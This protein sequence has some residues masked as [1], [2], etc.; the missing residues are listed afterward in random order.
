[1]NQYTQSRQFRRDDRARVPFA[2]IAILLLIT[3]I[4]IV[5]YLEVRGT[6]ELETD[7]A[8]AMD[9]AD[10]AVQTELREASM[11][12]TERAATAPLT[13]PANTTYGT[14]LDEERPFESYIEWL[15][16][17]EASSRFDATTQ[18]VGDVEATISVPEVTD[19]STFR[20]ALDRVQLSPERE[21]GEATGMVTVTLDDIEISAIRDGEELATRTETVEVS[22]PTPVIQQHERTQE[23]Q[24]RLNAGITSSGFSQRFNARI[25]A[26]GWARGYA[27]YSGMPVTEVIANRHIEPSVNS[28][29]F[30]TQQD[31]FGATDPRLEDS[32]RRGW[33]C[34]A[35]QD[36]EELYDGY[37]PGTVDVSDDICEASEWLFGEQHTGELPEAPEALDLLGNTPGMDE[38]ETISVNETAYL[39]LRTL[40]SGT[41]E[42]SIA[43]AIER[44]FTIDTAIDTDIETTSPTFG[45]E[46]PAPSAVAVESEKTYDG[47]DISDSGTIEIPDEGEEYYRFENVGVDIE[48]TET[49][50]WVWSDNEG[51]QRATTTAEDT[52]AVTL[53]LALAENETAPALNIH[54]FNENNVSYKYN[55][56]PMTADD[57]TVPAPPDGFENYADREKDIATE[58][59]DATAGDELEDWLVSHWSGV[60]NESELSLPEK[61]RITLDVNDEDA[62]ITTII[63]DIAALQSAVETLSHTFERA[64]LIHTGDGGPVGELIEKLNGKRVSYLER[65]DE[66][67]NVGQQ[68]VYEARYA[69]FELLFDDLGMV[70]EAHNEVMG[71]LGDELSGVDSSLDDAVS[72][73]QQGISAEPDSNPALDSP[74]ITPE[75]T[76]EISGSPTYLAGETITTDEVPAVAQDAN[77]SS[78]AMKNTNHL[79]LPYDSIVSGII[80]RV[81]SVIGLGS[82]DA[83]ITLKT[84]GEALRAG[85]LAESA[86]EAEDDYAERTQLQALND[87]VRMAVAEALDSFPRH[88]SQAM[89]SELYDTVIERTFDTAYPAAVQSADVAE[90]HIDEFSHASLAAI[91]LGNGSA[92]DPLIDGVTDA[93]DDDTIDR[94]TYAENL[95]SDDWQEVIAS[96]VHPAV[97]N[98]TGMATVTLSDTDTI[99]ALDTQVRQALQNVSTDIIEDRL[100]E[101]LGDGVFDL[102]EYDDWVDGI[103]KPMRVP[104]GLPLLPVP[105]MWKATVNVW[106]VEADGK[107]A[108][109]ELKANMSAPGRTSTTTYVRENST[110]EHKIGGEKQTLGGVDPIEFDGRSMLVVVVPPGGLG[111]GDRDDVDPECS[112][113]YPFTG[114]FNTEYTF[115]GSIPQQLPP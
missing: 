72:H 60:T 34:M 32:V 56:G 89:V 97:V 14:E 109:F 26:L 99:E 39:P 29:V 110:V 33:F 51:T 91:A 43:G 63:E 94:P 16:H 65:D 83:E 92:T 8:V 79:K 108:R 115:C 47:L 68:A 42:H 10:A 55:R 64:D 74:D 11:A 17:D 41:D 40:V 30:R 53:T 102:S 71:G 111:V 85:E 105:G 22:V 38:E 48:I 88:F 59:V 3:T 23:F 81:A 21:G 84:A 57:R 46:Q 18:Q 20:E 37:N 66:Y 24:E 13:E 4:G 93:L 103:D 31:V 100:D 27:Q 25:Y 76:Y 2:V 107:Y 62:V 96:A 12:A 49:K 78:L 82:S 36:G 5:G 52:L 77:F 86:T 101:Y 7:T 28:A 54:E 106:D 104:A 58:V 87:D 90:A 98:A 15:I 112:E 50:E 70:E 80:S 1:M 75:I 19:N 45:H 95:S 35:V 113:T 69:Y 114:E 44:T 9:R 73:L 6:D 67:Q 61:E